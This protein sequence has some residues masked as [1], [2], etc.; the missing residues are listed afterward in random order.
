MPQGETKKQM[1][2]WPSCFGL[3]EGSSTYKTSHKNSESN[4]N[5]NN[6]KS[7]QKNQIQEEEDD[8]E[9][10]EAEQ[11]KKKMS[12]SSS[13]KLNSSSSELDLDRPNI[14]DYLPSGSSIQQEPHG[15]LRL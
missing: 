1:G 6:N 15:E 3:R 13:G 5:N 9:A 12:S 7:P 2:G 14:E 10:E 11:V 8:D 4:Y